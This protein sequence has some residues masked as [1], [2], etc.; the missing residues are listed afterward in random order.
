MKKFVLIL[1]ALM[2]LVLIVYR[3]KVV[4]ERTQREETRRERRITPVEVLK[5]KK[6]GLSLYLDLVGD[7]KGEE[8]VDIFPKASGKLL[9]VKVREGDRV[10]KDQVVALVDRDVEGVKFQ[11][12]E[13]VS[14]VDGIVGM[15]YLDRGAEVSPPSPGPG[16]GTPLLRIINMDQVRVVV[17][18]VEED[19][20][21]IRV[22]QRATVKVDAYPHRTFSGVVSLIS[23]I[24]NQF[25]RTAKVEIALPNPDHLLKPGMFA[26]VRIFLGEKDDLILI[27]ASTIIEEGG[28]KRVFV[29]KQGKAVSRLVETGVSQNGWTEIKSGLKEDDSLIVAGQYLVKDSEPVKVVSGKGGEE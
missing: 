17:N 25:T 13:V 2:V 11:L 28:K 26:Y 6:G 9:E 14:P 27:P 21:K 10:K 15:I 4:L 18:V 12:A 7:V 23:P 8:E 20:G 19:L 22:G 16:M 29:V 1:I 5:V 24:V 3:A